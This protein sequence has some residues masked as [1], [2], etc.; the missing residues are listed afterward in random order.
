MERKKISIEEL[1]LPI[2]IIPF[3]LIL[4]I[5]LFLFLRPND[6]NAFF[7]TLNPFFRDKMSLVYLFVSFALFLIAIFLSF[8]KYGDIVLGPKN[9]KPAFSF[10]GWGAMMF[11][12]GMAADILYYGFTEWLNY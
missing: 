7:E 11:C 5:C 10:W 8:S 12:C 1:D 3:L 6:A 4:A 2:L 9:E